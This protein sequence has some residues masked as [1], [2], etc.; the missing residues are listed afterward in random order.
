MHRPYGA[1]P[2]GGERPSPSCVFLCELRACDAP[3]RPTSR[4]QAA[5]TDRIESRGP[6]EERNRSSCSFGLVAPELLS[7][8]TCKSAIARLMITAA[9][10]HSRAVFISSAQPR[11]RTGR[12][13]RPGGPNR[14]LTISRV[15]NWR[16]AASEEPNPG[17][18]GDDIFD[19]LVRSQIAS[20]VGSPTF[21]CHPSRHVVVQ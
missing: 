4:A 10:P 18:G 5:N 6:I 7:I 19:E 1:S 15:P 11:R 12:Q 21:V 20:S 14:D 16:I 2:P 13:G 17:Q 9:K 8:V 3:D